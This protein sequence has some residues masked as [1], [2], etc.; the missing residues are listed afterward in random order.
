MVAESS[1]NIRGVGQAGG[2]GEAAAESLIAKSIDKG[3]A[4]LAGQYSAHLQ[5]VERENQLAE[6]ERLRQAKSILLTAGAEVD[7][8]GVRAP[9]NV[10]YDTG[11]SFLA[12]SPRLVVG[13]LDKKIATLQ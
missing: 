5:Q 1:K 9:A 8:V 7:D 2:P 3:V 11:S 13:M 12:L 6:L 4:S 10:L